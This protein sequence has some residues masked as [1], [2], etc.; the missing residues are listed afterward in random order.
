MALVGSG[1][2]FCPKI[3]SGSSQNGLDAPTLSATLIFLQQFCFAID[4][5]WSDTFFLILY[6][7]GVSEVKF[8]NTIHDIPI[9]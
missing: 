3:G 7:I 5:F 6:S 8:C 4:I 2:G 1:S 9:L